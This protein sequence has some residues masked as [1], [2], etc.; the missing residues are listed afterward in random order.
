MPVSKLKTCSLLRL[1][2]SADFWF[3]HSHQ[4]PKL[5]IGGEQVYV[6]TQQIQ[7]FL[8]EAEKQEEV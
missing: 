5:H 1:N 3:E 6:W 4:G 8:R 7:A 2:C